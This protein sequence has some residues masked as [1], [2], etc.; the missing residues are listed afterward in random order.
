MKFQVDFENIIKFIV[1][2]EGDRNYI[3]ACGKTKFNAA[4]VVSILTKKK[5]FCN[6][7]SEIIKYI[8]I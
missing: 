3:K 8:L 2:L 5:N 7:M 6:S 1:L 4:N